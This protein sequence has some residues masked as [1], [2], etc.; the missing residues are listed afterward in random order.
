MGYKFKVY[1]RIK[2]QASYDLIQ[3]L[4]IMIRV[5]KSFSFKVLIF[6]YVYPITL[7]GKPDPVE[8]VK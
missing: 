8:L 5:I 1:F 3:I 4:T 7:N 2:V 6:L